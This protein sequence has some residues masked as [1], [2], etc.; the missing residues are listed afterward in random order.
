VTTRS[1]RV[2]VKNVGK[3]V[4]ESG[5]RLEW[6]SSSPRVRSVVNLRVGGGLLLRELHVKPRIDV[7]RGVMSSLSLVDDGIAET[8]LTMTLHM[9]DKQ[10]SMG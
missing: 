4:H 10:F 1:P 5:R 8:T 7:G 2:K 9:Q 3:S 6:Y